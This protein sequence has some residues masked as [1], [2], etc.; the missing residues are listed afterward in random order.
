MSI[1]KSFSVGEGDMFYIKH[2]SSNF[3]I[4]DCYLTEENKDIIVNE[5][6]EKKKEKDITRFISTHPDDD[7]IGGLKYLDDKIKILNFYSVKNEYDKEDSDDYKRYYK[8]RDDT[9]KA[10]YLFRGCKRKWM[11]E[12]DKEKKYGSSGIHILWPITTNS[13]FKDALKK[14]N[15]DESPNNISPIIEYSLNNGAKILW[16]G[17]LE[18]SFTE[19]IQDEIT[20]PAADVIF[21]PHHGRGSG[22]LP[23]KWLEQI[24]PKIIVIGEASSKHLNYYPG[25]NTITQNSAGDIT[26]DCDDNKV[27]IY[28]SSNTYS[29]T[30]LNDE[31][32]SNTYGNYIGSLDV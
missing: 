25:Y 18:S 9:K 8:L 28:V 29:V 6:I 3:T 20:L 12:N 4:I 7:H 5:I 21:A 32:K 23:K 1:V 19:K 13:D 2:G 15:N 31:K 14:T 17:D 22:K 11:N 24:N 26:F 16:F 10:F 30:F 27:H